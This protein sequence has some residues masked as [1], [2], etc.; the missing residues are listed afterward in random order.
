MASGVAAAA[1]AA[2]A[3]YDFAP[4]DDFLNDDDDDGDDGEES[5]NRDRTAAAAAAAAPFVEDEDDFLG[6][7][8]A[9]EAENEAVASGTSASVFSA[10]ATASAAA[11]ARSAGE[12]EARRG[13]AAAAAAAGGAETGVTTVMAVA[14]IG[15]SAGEGPAEYMP[16]SSSTTGPSTMQI[17]HTRC[18]PFWPTF[19]WLGESGDG[20]RGGGTE[21]RVQGHSRPTYNTGLVAHGRVIVPTTPRGPRSV[22]RIH[23][24]Q[25][26]VHFTAAVLLCRLTNMH[27]ELTRK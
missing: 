6:A 3:A 8:V 2:A 20:R 18:R 7:D 22:C 23:I 5:A 27:M 10:D 1:A 26:E 16:C 13:G 17:S 9:E 4:G 25:H 21:T 11:T 12:F 24:I 14:L 15:V 19:V